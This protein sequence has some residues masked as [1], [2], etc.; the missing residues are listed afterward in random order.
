MINMQL[1]FYIRGFLYAVHR[2]MCIQTSWHILRPTNTICSSSR[3]YE[4]KSLIFYKTTVNN[5]FIWNS[6]NLVRPVVYLSVLLH[7]F[8]AQRNFGTAPLPSLQLQRCIEAG[9]APINFVHPSAWRPQVPPV[10]SLHSPVVL[11]PG[12]RLSPIWHFTIVRT[13][14]EGFFPFWPWL[15]NQ[16]E[17]KSR[18]S[19]ILHPRASNSI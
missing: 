15:D 1:T 2:S 18:S 4:T 14:R 11:F 17:L 7:A 10:R 9:E 13:V 6:I 8:C 12:R 16:N 19:C 5:F 3:S